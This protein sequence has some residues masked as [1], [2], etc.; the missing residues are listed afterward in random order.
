MAPD[1]PYGVATLGSVFTSRMEELDRHG[2]GLAVFLEPKRRVRFRD[3]LQRPAARKKLLLELYH[4]EDR[5]DDRYA[6]LQEMHIKHD[7]HVADVLSK[8]EAEGAPG[9]C[10]VVSARDDVPRQMPLRE[11][12]PALMSTGAGFISC[13]E[14]RL[15]LYVSEDGSNV[16]VLRR[17]GDG[18][19]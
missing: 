19:R 2:A 13:I 4:F 3:A 11:A 15:G 1:G 8:L 9:V 16:F 17:P 12:V 6:Q 14:A 5:L 10:V 7:Q 18:G